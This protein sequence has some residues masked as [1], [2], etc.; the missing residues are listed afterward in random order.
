MKIVGIDIGINNLGIAFFSS[1]LEKTFCFKETSKDSVE[2]RLLHLYNKIDN[3]FTKELE[4]ENE[5]YLIYEIPYFAF[6]SST[7]KILDYVVG[8]IHLLA[9]KHD[10][11]LKSYTAK[12]IKKAINVQNCKEKKS[13]E[14]NKR[15]VKQSVENILKSDLSSLTDHEI[16]AIAIILCFKN[17]EE[18]K[19]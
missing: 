5:K 4:K 12:E 2:K 14:E 13:R 11:Q 1:S 15:L 17:K 9:A 6:N 7:G 19:C 10:L 18:I 3:L 8:I 16:D